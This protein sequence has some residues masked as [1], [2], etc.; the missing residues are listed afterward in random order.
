MGHARKRAIGG[1]APIT[2]TH[3]YKQRVR[4]RALPGPASPRLVAPNTYPPPRTVTWGGEV[5]LIR[6]FSAGLGMSTFIMHIMQAVAVEAHEAKLHAPSKSQPTATKPCG[7]L[8]ARASMAHQV[9][10]PRSRSVREVFAGRSPGGVKPPVWRGRS[11][12][13]MSLRAFLPSRG[14]HLAAVH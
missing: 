7:H 5:G 12:S 4:K 6:M 13:D 3:K 8:R 1:S 14:R 10:Q 9:W 2:P 11:H